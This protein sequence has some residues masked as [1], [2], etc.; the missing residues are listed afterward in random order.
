M[1][2]FGLFTLPLVSGQHGHQWSAP[3][4]P[5]ELGEAGAGWTTISADTPQT[6][7]YPVTDMEKAAFKLQN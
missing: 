7:Q 4:T 6:I 2:A 3:V 1:R 5:P